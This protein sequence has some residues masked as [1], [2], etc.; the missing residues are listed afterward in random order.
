MFRL[1]RQVIFVLLVVALVS[2]FPARPSQSA[3]R[4]QNI[5]GFY[6][7]LNGFS[8]SC[9]SGGGSNVAVSGDFSR[10]AYLPAVNSHTATFTNPASVSAFS[11]GA[12]GTAQNGAVGIFYSGFLSTS[13]AAPVNVTVTID[14]TANGAVIGSSSISVTCNAV[15]A[16]PVV[17]TSNTYATSAPVIQ[18]GRLNTDLAAPVIV[19]QGS[20]R[21]FVLNPNTNTG[22]QILTVSDAR[23][24][25]VGV[26]SIATVLASTQHPYTGQPVKVYRLPN[27]EFQLN[28]AYR[29][30]KPYIFVWNE[31]ATVRYY[32]AR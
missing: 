29:D 17:Q 6:Y 12:I 10:I 20:I 9:I 14:S 2:I 16:A 27:G 8:G 1:S 28:T 3:A 13:G 25:E 23:I 30:G 31:D 22:I 19:Y 11:T 26:P 24:D 7:L 4:P 32:L 18:D 5:I 21:L 15:G